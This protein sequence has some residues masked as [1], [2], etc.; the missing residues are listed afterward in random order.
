MS[1]EPR[2][3]TGSAKLVRGALAALVAVGSAAL[4]HTAGGHYAPH[5]L[6]ILLTLAASIPV[7]VQLSAVLLS[8]LRLAAAV[9]SSQALLHG[10][11][12]VF[13]APA[14]A[15]SGL[16]AGAHG[17]HGGSPILSV[18]DPGVDYEF[19][20]PSSVVEASQHSAHSVAGQT[21]AAM[22]GAH[23]AAAV[24]AWCLLRRGETLLQAIAEQLSIAPVGRLLTA[25]P[26]ARTE[27]RRISLT[28]AEPENNGNTWLGAGPRSLRGPPTLVKQPG[29]RC[30]EAAVPLH[31]TERAQYHYV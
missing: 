17:H 14:A 10:L 21:D 18:P 26:A 1:V 22:I 31:E 12:A 11:F 27:P 6:V 16:P 24:F 15:S 25:Q 29:N 2:R 5:P 8:R 28:C 30:A 20:V 7:C 13:P 19:A 3:V 4:A 9:L 23:L